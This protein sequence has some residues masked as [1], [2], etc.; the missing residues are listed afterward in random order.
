[1]ASTVDS[2]Q[3]GAVPPVEQPFWGNI[4]PA[5]DVFR[6]GRSVQDGYARGWGLQ[7]DNLR[8]RIHKDPLFVH[9]WEFANGRTVM[10][11]WNQLNLF[12]I[13]KYFLAPFADGHI[14]EFGAYRGG[15]AM[16]MAFIAKWLYPGMKIYAL[17][18][19][20]GMPQTDPAIDAHGPGGFA[21]VDIAELR[22]TATQ[23]GLDNLVFVQGMFEDTAPDLLANVIGPKVALAHI[24]CDIYSG[25][26]YSYEVVKPY[27]MPRG[28]IVFDDATV[29]SCIGATE[30]VEELV[31]Q[32]D[33]L[34]SEQIYPHFVFRAP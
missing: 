6:N 10:G 23:R 15:N 8:E 20:T 14:V 34:R 7:F 24:D 31:I 16:F 11:E 17:D 2:G 12:L 13:L 30:A 32:R 9:A 22:A 21:D 28:Y 29:A 18:T 33:G 1:M 19:Y 3:G 25:V 4:K 5:P 27:M 26:A